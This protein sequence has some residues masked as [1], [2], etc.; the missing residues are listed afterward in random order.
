MLKLLIGLVAAGI[1]FNAW[2]GVVADQRFS[3]PG[4]MV[5]VDDHRLHLY[6]V[7][8]GHPTVVLEA[9]AGMWSFFFGRLQRAL[10]DSVRV[11]AY[12]RAGLGWSERGT[13]QFDIATSAGELRELLLASRETLPVV[14]VGHSLGANIAIYYAATFPG[15]LAG[16]VLVDPGVPADWVDGYKGTDEDAQRIAGCGWRS[17]VAAGA[18][19]VGV[20]RLAAQLARAGSKSLS[21]DEADQYRA[22]MSRARTMS[23]TL[24]TLVFLPKSAVEAREARA[25]GDVPMTVVYSADTRGPQGNETAADV[26]AWH[27]R[28]LDSIRV[29]LQG[30]THARGPI[31]VPGVTHTT[32][33]LDSTSVKIIAAATMRLVRMQ[34]DKRP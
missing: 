19:Y 20:A 26:A 21:E 27:A 24:C 22:G 13:G 14:L 33:A 32:V 30:T 16:A 29:L 31:V 4:T 12:D 23:A 34:Q 5:R 28:T 15:D 7:G 6:C 8:Q 25:F 10:S 2:R 11:C 18:A 17:G 9:G 3:P 1:G